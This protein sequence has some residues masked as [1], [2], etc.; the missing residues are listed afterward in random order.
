MGWNHNV[1]YHDFVL[2]AIPSGCERALD[3]GCGR[4][5]LSRK[6]AH[7]S[8]EVVAIDADRECIENAAA[9]NVTF[10]HADILAHPF[11]PGTCDFVVAV[12]SLHHLPLRPALELVARLLRPGGVLVIVGLYRSHHPHRLRSRMHRA[13]DQLDDPSVQRRRSERSNQRAAGN[14]SRNSRC[15]QHPAAGRRISPPALLPLLFHLAEVV[16]AARSFTASVQSRT[17]VK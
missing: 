15:P 10:I 3:A 8:K 1:Q 9:P 7:R 6:L 5:G 16:A 14:P 2:R 4:G 11:P 13:P 12:A 17:T